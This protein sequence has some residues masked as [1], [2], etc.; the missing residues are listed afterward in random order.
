MA[1]ATHSSLKAH[2]SSI[3]P[4]PRPTISKSKS[5]SL[6]LFI[7]LTISSLASS[8]WTKQGNNKV[9]QIGY[10]LL[11][12]LKISLIA[13]PVGAVTIPILVG[14]LG[15]FCLWDSSNNPLAANSFFKASYL[16]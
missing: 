3:D 6:A 7:C 13:A 1:F 11:I 8:P 5:Y 14:Y 4:P 10:L 9:S 12:V 15:I 16:R 2:K